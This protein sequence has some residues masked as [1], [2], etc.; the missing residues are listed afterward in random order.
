MQR[1]GHGHELAVARL[2][3]A[4]PL[5][6]ARLRLHAQVEQVVTVVACVASVELECELRVLKLERRRLWMQ[7]RW[8]SVHHDQRS[9]TLHGGGQ[10]GS[11]HGATGRA[12]FW[13]R[14]ASGR[15]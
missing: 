8:T 10:G 5:M 2:A 1:L 7:L 9:A 12:V 4:E 14:G 6:V 3:L 13:K 15:G 11:C